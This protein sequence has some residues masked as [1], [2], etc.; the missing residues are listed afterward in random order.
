MDCGAEGP[1]RR[2]ITFPPVRAPGWGVALLPGRHGP[3]ETW[4]PNVTRWG[5]GGREE[6]QADTR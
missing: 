5:K 4:R 1:G 3:T 6:K 2:A